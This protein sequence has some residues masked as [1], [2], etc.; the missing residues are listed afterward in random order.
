MHMYVYERE[1]E[2][3]RIIIL[4]CLLH[5]LINQLV[6]CIHVILIS[7]CVKE[8]GEHK[9]PGIS[10]AVDSINTNATRYKYVYHHH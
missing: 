4:E 2:N 7:N 3:K 1:K 6:I 8:G 5:A 9:V 10:D